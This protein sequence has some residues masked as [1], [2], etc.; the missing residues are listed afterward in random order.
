MRLKPPL[1]ASLHLRILRLGVV[2]AVTAVCILSWQVT[3][4]ENV[5]HIVQP[6]EN[7]FRI[8]LKYGVSWVAIMNANGL[9]DTTIYVGQSLVIPDAV[10]ANDAP[11]TPLPAPTEVAPNAVAPLPSPAAPAPVA[12]TPASPVAGTTTYTVQAGDTLFQI[13]ARHGVNL[14]E[15]AAANNL[16]NLALIYPGQ[17]LFIPAGGVATVPAVTGPTSAKQII[18]SISEQH[19]YAYENDNLVYSFIAST[20]MPGAN[21]APG[22]YSVLDKIPNAYGANWDLWMPNW[23]GIYWAGTLENGIHALPIL[24]NG[25]RLW[26]GYLGTP[27]SFGCIILGVEDSQ[28]LYDWAEVG[29]PVYIRY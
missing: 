6:G 11:A 19:L 18:I 14:A 12:E 27:V 21:T 8:G 4:A 3:R 13:A 9:P 25:Q 1:P 28:T 23:L 20:G 15:L 24:S 2:A 26:D 29:T 16:Y 22:T 5:T 7:L 10:S 17:T